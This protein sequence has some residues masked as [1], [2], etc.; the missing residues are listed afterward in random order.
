[1]LKKYVFKLNGVHTSLYSTQ[2]SNLVN[3]SEPLCNCNMIRFNEAIK[4]VGKRKI[5]NYFLRN[6]FQIS[7]TL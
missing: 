5:E 7:S 4:N 2:S 6:Y 1:M 3:I